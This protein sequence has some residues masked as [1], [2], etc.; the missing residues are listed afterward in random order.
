MQNLKDQ[1]VVIRSVKVKA[2]GSFE[3]EDLLIPLTVF[4]I[5]CVIE[6]W[7]VQGSDCLVHFRV[8]VP[9]M[10]L[11]TEFLSLHRSL[12]DKDLA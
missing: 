6:T 5:S 10:M 7:P 1:P 3:G 8:P 12:W 4:V 11:G 9:S 2:E